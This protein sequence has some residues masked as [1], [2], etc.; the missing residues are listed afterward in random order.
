MFQV[1]FADDSSEDLKHG[2]E[3][4]EVEV[5]NDPEFWAMIAERRKQ[6]CL[7]AAELKKK[8]ELMK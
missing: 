1:L 7:T 6:P 2:D 4:L 5:V 3:V 8:M